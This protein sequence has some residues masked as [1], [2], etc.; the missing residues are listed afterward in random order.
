MPTREE[1]IAKVRAYHPR[2]KSELLGQAYDFAVKHHGAAQ[3]DSGEAY[4]SHPIRVASLLADVR[5]DEVTIVAGLLH[6]V[7]E[8]TEIDIGDIEVRFGAD[9]AELVDGVTKLDKL[10]FTS[11]EAAQAEN[12]QKFILAMTSD[13]RVLLVKLA[14]RLHNMETLHFRK[15]PESRQRT[16]R[17]TMDI[18]APLARRVGLYDVAARMDDLAFQELNPE[19]RRAILYR[20][21]ELERENKGDLDRIREDLT[22]LLDETGLK[23]RL[24]GRRKQPYSLWR[25]LERKSISF[26]DVADLFAFRIML[27]DV[28]DCYAVLGVIHTHWAC[29]PDRF[30]D[31]IS[32]PKPNGY[33]SLHTTVRA[34]GNRRVEL[35]I[36]TKAMDRT[37]EYGVAAHWG[38][39]NRSYGFDV[40][41]A[42]AAGLDPEANLKA[43]AELLRDGAEPGEFLEHAKLEMY[44][45]H[46]FT[47][48]PKGKLIILPAG[49]M[50]LDFAYAVHSAVGDTAIGA[51]INGEEKPMRRPLKNGDVVDVIR[52][53]A[54]A[55]MIGWEAMTYTGRA[56]SKQRKLERDREAAE[57]RRLGEGLI[58]QA[59][60]RAGADPVD[61]MLVEVANKFGISSIDDLRE[62]AGRGRILTSA[63]VSA[64]FPGYEPERTTDSD[65]TPIDSRHA[66]LFV[67]GKDLTPGVTLH[68][69][70]CCRPLP[71]DRI[72]G[73]QVP[74]KG[75]VVHV[76]SCPRLAQYDDQPELWRD[77][78]WTELAKTGAVAVGRVR[79]NAANQ[80]GVLAKLC[81]AVAE[82]S[83]NIV[84]ISTSLRQRDFIELM[85]DIEVEDLKRL[86][87]ILAAL[88]S[89]AVVDRAVRDQEAQDDQ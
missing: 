82:S 32:V 78:K 87:Q 15:K 46:V 18:Y 81:S 14:D 37:A 45:E 85:M 30:R 31:F 1:L 52:G 24:R 58:N 27:A 47:F 8:D 89:L 79:I 23:Y 40:D 56:K 28:K 84:G 64:A 16:A 69:G 80:R 29:I 4:Y 21:E 9:V 7:V 39:K 11:K 3:R 55:P 41:S 12:F 54:P 48:T 19:A 65:K 35:Q 17:E 71:G 36:R 25:K 42:R 61:V 67:E 72:I 26:R 20:L 86:T 50:P 5:L 6:D 74:D 73:V 44:R 63:I 88:R 33:A 57:F 38:Y 68:L 76:S 59:L 53:R 34:S 60:R 75:L 70:H 22:A 49:A 66:P 10:E 62:E 83:G 77:L 13:I 51:R 43:F 2:V